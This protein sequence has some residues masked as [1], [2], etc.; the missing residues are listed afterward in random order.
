MLNRGKLLTYYFFLIYN[1]PQE[2]FINVFVGITLITDITITKEIIL[3][4]IVKMPSDPTTAAHIFV[5]AAI[6]VAATNEVPPPVIPPNTYTTIGAAM[7]IDVKDI[8]TIDIIHLTT[9]ENILYLAKNPET[10]PNTT[11]TG[12]K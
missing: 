4:K 9:V 11:L 5:P 6:K 10:I 1:S 7:I 2:N 12:I 3:S 8:R